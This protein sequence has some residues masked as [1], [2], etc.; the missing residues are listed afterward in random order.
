MQTISN[1]MGQ[2]NQ[3]NRMLLQVMN[4]NKQLLNYLHRQKKWVRNELK[5]PPTHILRPTHGR[6]AHMVG[7]IRYRST[8]STVGWPPTCTLSQHIA[9]GCGHDLVTTSTWTCE[10]WLDCHLNTLDTELHSS[11]CNPIN[12]ATT[13]TPEATTQLTGNIVCREVYP[14]SNARQSFPIWR[15]EVVLFVAA[16]ASALGHIWSCVW[17]RPY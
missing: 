15:N 12:V 9:W 1:M 4:A 8:I 17:W 13:Y 2:S 16:F 5:R 3:M 14:T 10:I 6:H 11:Q 7:P